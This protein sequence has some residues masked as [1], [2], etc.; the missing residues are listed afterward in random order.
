MIAETA[1]HLNADSSTVL[2]DIEDL[3]RFERK[4]VGLLEEEYE[5]K[6][7][8]FKLKDIDKEFKNSK[9]G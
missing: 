3:A 5:D 6:E 4:L 9:V 7:E 1:L 8:Y 2:R